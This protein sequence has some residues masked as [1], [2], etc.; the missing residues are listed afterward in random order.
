[1]ATCRQT[2]MSL[3][4]NRTILDNLDNHAL[5]IDVMER[6]RRKIE[7]EIVGLQ[8]NLKH[9]DRRIQEHRHHLDSTRSITI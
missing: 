8:Q 2:G 5:S 1:M 7:N 3:A 4:D 9:L 6:A